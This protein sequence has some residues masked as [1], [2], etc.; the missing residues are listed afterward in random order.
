MAVSAL[1]H[2]SAR[3]HGV[4][5][6]PSGP[7]R[8][9]SVAQPAAPMADNRT[10]LP[11][12]ATWYFDFISPFAYLQ[13]RRLAREQA[14][15]RVTPRPILFVAVLNHLQQR[16]PAEIAHKRAFTYQFVQWQAERAGVRLRFP[17]AHPFNPLPALR[18]CL[19]AGSSAAAVEAIFTHIWEH[20][21][22]AD[23][24][25]ALADVAARLGIDDVEAAL[26][27][28][29]VKATLKANTDQ[30]LALGVFGVPMLRIEERLFWGNDA[31]DFALDYARDPTRFAQGEMA[32]LSDLPIAARRA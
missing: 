27:R 24:A 10:R 13:W 9:S 5:P 2:A 25:R 22:V 6:G 26:Q 17:P 31:T 11:L 1:A 14:T 15:V 21:A 23:S 7:I 16:G 28:E 29:D 32:R 12:A 30:A 4:V 20:G 8:S 3:A 19:A 18:L